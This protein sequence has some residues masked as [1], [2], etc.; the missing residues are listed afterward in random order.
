MPPRNSSPSKASSKKGKA[1]V[2]FGANSSS[3]KRKSS[4]AASPDPEP[5]STKRARTNDASGFGSTSAGASTST[6][7]TD[8]GDATAAKATP[9]KR[10]A[11]NRWGIRPTEVPANAKLTQRAFQHFIC[12]LCGLLT[13]TDVLPSATAAR[14]H[15]ERRF[16]DTNDVRQHMRTLVDESRTAVSAALELSTTLIRDAE[17]LSG[18]IANDI[19]RLPHHHL[20]SVFTMILKAGLQGFCPD[21][22]GPVQS[23]YNELHRHLAVSG[24][25]FLAESYA[26]SALE[27]NNKV[28]ANSC[29]HRAPLRYKT[30]MERRRP[31]SLAK[32][33]ERGVDFKARGRMRGGF[34][35]RY[36]V[37]HI[38]LKPTPT[39]STL[40][41]V[42]IPV[43]AKS[44]GA[45]RLLPKF[46]TEE[47]DPEA[48]AYRK[49]NA[50]SGQKAPKTRI[51]P[52][53][54]LPASNI[55]VILPAD[56]PIDFFTPEFYN[57]LSVKE[58]ARYVDTGV[59]FP[60]ADFAFDEVHKGWKTMGKK[61]FMEMYGNDVLE[62]YNIPSPEEIAAI[63]NSDAEDDE[64]EINLRIQMTRRMGRWRSTKTFRRVVFQFFLHSYLDVALDL[65]RL[66]RSQT[67]RMRLHKYGCSALRSDLI[68]KL[69]QALW[70]CRAVG[71]A[72][73]GSVMGDHTDVWQSHSLPRIPL[74]RAK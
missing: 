67:L 23:N 41:E 27:V 58:R 42:S 40:W 8:A 35:S 5:S 46:L 51:R 34:E 17:R 16:E 26:L 60:L 20:A 38:S 37:W 63:P 68:V 32:S 59:A 39:M 18:P 43:S 28:A 72:R 61:E 36:S 49:R 21:L 19:T 48:E 25:Q 73:V 52:N 29:Q 14:K 7:T 62:Q 33:I 53:P 70:Q 22:E 30:K 65:S 64:E 1:K 55:G 54:L 45:I 47:L 4:P 50:K 56:V 2:N 10:R 57:A 71:A 44:Q 31:G 74:W 11:R 66:K 13:Q 9:A 3:R 12:V 24:F 6:G 15:Y 69:T